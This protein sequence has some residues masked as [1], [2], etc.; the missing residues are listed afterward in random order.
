MN[1]IAVVV[2]TMKFAEGCCGPLKAVEGRQDVY[3]CNSA[4]GVL[5]GN[6]EADLS[7]K[8]IYLKRST[9]ISYIQF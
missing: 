8:F 4:R 1:S 6:R 2:I 3:V 7:K 9:C 5:G